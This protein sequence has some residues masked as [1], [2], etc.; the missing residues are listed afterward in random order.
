MET[1]IKLLSL[2]SRSAMVHRLITLWNAFSLACFAFLL[3]CWFFHIELVLTL[4]LFTCNLCLMFKKMSSC[5]QE[6]DKHKIPMKPH[7]LILDTWYLILLV[8]RSYKI[9][10]VRIP[11][12]NFSQ[13]K[14]HC[15]SIREG[16]FVTYIKNVTMFSPLKGWGSIWA[17]LWFFKKCI[18]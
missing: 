18:F 6:Q 16:D 13:R 3:W 2:A 17:P 11:A 4:I 14:G 7:V 12:L 9:F 8:L 5:Y 10:L 15:I 1:L